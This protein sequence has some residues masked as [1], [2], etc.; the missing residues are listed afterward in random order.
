MTE[1]SEPTALTELGSKP[2]LA[3]HNSWV[4][5]AYRRRKR[6]V[7]P[8]CERCGRKNRRWSCECGWRW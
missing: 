5:N 2:L 1:R 8:R 3:E 6:Q 7:G 4:R